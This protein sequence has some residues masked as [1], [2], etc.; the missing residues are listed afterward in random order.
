MKKST[1]STDAVRLLIDAIKS[2]LKTELL[3]ELRAELTAQ[4]AEA[5]PDRVML[6]IADVGRRYGVGRKTIR[7]MIK[8]GDLSAVER[9]S[10]GGRIGQFMHLADCERALARRAK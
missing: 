2:E 3:Y 6:S 10:R 9:I 8:S 7:A 4:H 5:E 1:Q